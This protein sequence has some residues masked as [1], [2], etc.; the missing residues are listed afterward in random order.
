[1]CIV[2]YMPAPTAQAVFKA[3]APYE[4]YRVQIVAE[5]KR[6]GGDANRWGRDDWMAMA[7]AITRAEDVLEGRR[8]AEYVKLSVDLKVLR[9][10]LEEASEP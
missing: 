4:T 5:F 2:L 7:N 6:L 3:I 1:M 9:R 10:S 8:A